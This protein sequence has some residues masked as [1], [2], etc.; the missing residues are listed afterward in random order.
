MDLSWGKAKQLATK[1]TVSGDL[2]IV[3]RNN[4]TKERKAL[5]DLARPVFNIKLRAL[6]L[7][8]LHKRKI[9]AQ[10]KHQTL[11]S[12][13]FVSSDEKIIES[14]R[15][16]EKFLFLFCNSRSFVIHQFITFDTFRG[17]VVSLNSW[18]SHSVLGSNV[19]FITRFVAKKK[20]RWGIRSDS[21]NIQRVLP[22]T[23]PNSTHD[24]SL[25]PM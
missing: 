25:T 7:C 8:W 13:V 1:T 16:T 23:R 24:P 2:I 15:S 19:R 10:G 3:R 5:K 4:L 17:G 9:F 11:R 12:I 18:W 21:W 14:L 22:R 6:R 20:N